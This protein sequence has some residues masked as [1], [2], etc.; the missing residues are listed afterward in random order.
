M[1]TLF[2]NTLCQKLRYLGERE[3]TLT[4]FYQQLSI[5]HCQVSLY[6]NNYFK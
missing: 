2:M 1:N 4:M 3:P 5:A 6:A